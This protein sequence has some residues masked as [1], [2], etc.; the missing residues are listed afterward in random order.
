VNTGVVAPIRPEV[1]AVQ[2]PGQHRVVGG[3]GGVQIAMTLVDS[4]E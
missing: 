1:S 4:A 2:E 3:I